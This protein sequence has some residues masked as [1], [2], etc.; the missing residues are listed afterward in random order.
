MLARSGAD[1]EPQPALAPFSQLAE[2]ESCR[3]HFL[4]NFFCVLKK[5]FSRLREDDLFAQPV[6]KTTA[7]IGLQCFDGVADAG[8]SQM[9]FAC[10]LGKTAG[11]GQHAKRPNLPTVEW[12]IHK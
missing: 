2:G 11:A 7:H 3:I 9:K 1:A 4:Q 5:L 8:L 10:G 6:Q 12:L